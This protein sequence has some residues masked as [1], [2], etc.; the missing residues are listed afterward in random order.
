MLVIDPPPRDKYSDD[1]CFVAAVVAHTLPVSE[2]IARRYPG[3]LEDDAG[4]TDVAIKMKG[5][6]RALVQQRRVFVIFDLLGLVEVCKIGSNPDDECFV[7]T[8]TPL[9]NALIVDTIKTVLYPEQR[10]C[11]ACRSLGFWTIH[12]TLCHTGLY[13]SKWCHETFG[14][15]HQASC[16]VVFM[17]LKHE[18][19]RIC[20]E[21]LALLSFIEWTDPPIEGKKP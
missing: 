2:D 6:S 20:S 15:D 18:I 12:C 21:F 1:E 3:I 10:Y 16:K 14:P 17:S 5:I 19:T 13:C 8:R 11:D 4:L 9:E 7:M